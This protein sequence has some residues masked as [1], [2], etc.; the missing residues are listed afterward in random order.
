VLK[1]ISRSK[2]ELQPVLDT[3]VESFKPSDLIDG[4]RRLVAR[5]RYLE[6]VTEAAS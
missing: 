3:L 1:V 4:L 5:T 6:R 2:F